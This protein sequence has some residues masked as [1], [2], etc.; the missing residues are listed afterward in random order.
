MKNNQSNTPS[1]SN[2]ADR[3]KA[4]WRSV[5]FALLLIVFGGLF[6]A[7]VPFSKGLD[8]YHSANSIRMIDNLGELV[9]QL[10]VKWTEL[11]SLDEQWETTPSLTSRSNTQIEITKKE[12]EAQEIV[13]SI[14]EGD[15]GSIGDQIAAINEL[16]LISRGVLHEVRQQNNSGGGGNDE[17]QREM[18]TIQRK[19]SRIVNR[20]EKEADKL[21]EIDVR[22]V[23]L[24]KK[25]EEIQDEIDKCQKE[26]KR[27]ASDLS[28]L[29]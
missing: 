12:K 6:G 25:K 15:F 27:L 28:A 1:K 21:S 19:I 14:K 17:L 13:N 9:E 5:F 29:E 18:D 24:K 3:K 8:Q 2:K 23:N 26:I 16:F 22:T 10:K 4:I 20:L 11:K 7:F